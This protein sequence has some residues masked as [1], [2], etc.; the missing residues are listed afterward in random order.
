V[1]NIQQDSFVYNL[2]FGQNPLLQF[3]MQLLFCPE[4]VDVQPVLHILQ[5]IVIGQAGLPINT[6]VS[7]VVPWVGLMAIPEMI[8][9]RSVGTTRFN[10]LVPFIIPTE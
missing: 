3:F 9:V 8:A 1:R 4:Q 10:I 7:I 5:S 6:S 2:Q